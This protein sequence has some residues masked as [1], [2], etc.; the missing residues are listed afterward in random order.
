MGI[1]LSVPILSAPTFDL[2]S[3][4]PGVL[5]GSWLVLATPDAVELYS[6]TDAVTSSRAEFGLSGKT[7]RLSIA[8][9]N[10]AKFDDAVRTTTVYAQSELLPLAEAPISPA[11]T[12]VV[13]ALQRELPA[14]TGHPHHRQA[15]RMEDVSS[16]PRPREVVNGVSN[17]YWHSAANY[18][19]GS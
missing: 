19:P 1:D 2:D 12:G 7:T 13:S 6:V 9:E 11:E 10:R 18:Q 16:L 17:W 5:E 8:G 3:V 14:P 4:Y 15:R